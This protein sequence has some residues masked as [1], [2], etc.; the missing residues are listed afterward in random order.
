MM[1]DAR[2]MIAVGLFALVF[3]IISLLAFVPTIAANELF[4]TIATLIV[5]TA[6]VSGVVT[7]YFGS[8]K[9]SS[10]KDQ[11]ISK[12]LDKDANGK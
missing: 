5:G 3:Y 10:D 12:Q 8:S 2:G 6:F 1:P 9:N 4:K 11:T 7:F